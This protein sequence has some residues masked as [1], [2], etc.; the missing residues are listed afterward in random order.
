MSTPKSVSGY[1]VNVKCQGDQ[2]FE[3]IDQMRRIPVYA[4]QTAEGVNLHFSTKANHDD[5][6]KRVARRISRLS[7]EPEVSGKF[8]EQVDTNS[9]VK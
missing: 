3:V 5:L 9:G 8:Q 7:F 2:K 4:S 1:V 6:L